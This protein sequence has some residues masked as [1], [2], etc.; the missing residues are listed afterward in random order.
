[1][2]GGTGYLG[3]VVVAV[4]ADEGRDVRVLARDEDR[5]RRVLPAGVEVV[6]GDVFDPDSLARATAGCEAVLHLAAT[7][8]G[9]PEEIHHANVDGARTVLDA[10]RSAGARRFVHTSTGAAIMDA[11][12]LVA[13]EPVAPP[14]LTDP[15]ST[16]KIAAEELV[17]AADGIEAV[18]VSPAS[19]YGPSP[20]GPESYNGLFRAAAAG[21]VPAVVDAPMAWVLAE[22]AAR[23]HVLALDGGEPGRRYVLCGEVARVGRVLHAYAD[24][25]GGQRVALLPP[26][27][28]LGPDANTF[29]RR[30]EVYGKFPPVHV[31]DAGARGLGFAPRGVDDGIALT[32]AWCG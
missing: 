11:T 26:G 30:S 10:A 9:T 19:I 7:V 21:E 15:Y 17:L 4:L 24:A 2:T 18:V 31:D 28:S 6:V 5:A 13:E 32:A 1:M 14:A 3:S 12:G 23:G 8:G 27:S 29:A 16:S 20:R 25:V 22:D